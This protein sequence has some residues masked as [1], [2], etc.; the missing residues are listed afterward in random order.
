MATTFLTLF[1]LSWLSSGSL[2]CPHRHQFTSG[3]CVFSESGSRPRRDR[4]YEHRWTAACLRVPPTWPGH[5]T[6]N[7]PEIMLAFIQFISWVLGLWGLIVSDLQ[8][9]KI[10]TLH[11]CRFTCCWV[12]Q[13]DDKNNILF[14]CEI[15]DVPGTWSW[16]SQ[17]YSTT[18]KTRLS[19]LAVTRKQEQRWMAI[20]VYYWIVLHCTANYDLWHAFLVTLKCVASL[21][22]PF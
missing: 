18:I 3:D 16:L 7:V 5:H 11:C 1:L 9:G 17:F 12:Q 20:P 4:P 6:G 19:L 21:D 8:T 13:H 2:L 14:Q 15:W 10:T 22:E